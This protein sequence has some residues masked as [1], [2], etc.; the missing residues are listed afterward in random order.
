MKYSSRR[1]F[2]KSVSLVGLSIPLL[3]PNLMFGQSNDDLFTFRS[4]YMEIIMLR[5]Y[6]QL[7]SLWIDSLGQSKKGDSPLLPGDNANVKYESVISA[8]SISYRTSGQGIDSLPA[9]DFIFSDKRIQIVSGESNGVPFNIFI[10]QELNHVTV[11]GVMKEAN[12]VSLPCLVHLPDMGTF[13]DRK[14]VV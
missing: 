7:S 11:L 9:W 10:N 4:P 8:N 14:S 12:K 2:I 1:K 3:K 13:R 6:P 5:N